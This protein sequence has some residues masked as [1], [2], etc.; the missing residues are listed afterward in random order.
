MRLKNE[1]KL[2]LII[3]SIIYLFVMYQIILE[4]LNDYTKYTTLTIC[5][6]NKTNS[7]IIAVIKNKRKLVNIVIDKKTIYVETLYL[8]FDYK[9]DKVEIIIKNKNDI[10]AENYVAYPEFIYSDRGGSMTNIIIESLNNVFNVM[11]SN[12]PEALYFD[13]LKYVNK[14]D[15]SHYIYVKYHLSHFD[16]YNYFFNN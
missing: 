16:F 10:I 2:P 1:L 15:I 8:N 5:I 3:T 12:Y 7:D 13:D 11:Y 4:A 14:K 6:Y 9:K